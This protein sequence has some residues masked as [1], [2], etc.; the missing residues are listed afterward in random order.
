MKKEIISPDRLIVA[1]SQNVKERKYWLKK[2]SGK[3]SKSVWR[4]RAMR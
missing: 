1:A 2:M 3:L 4:G